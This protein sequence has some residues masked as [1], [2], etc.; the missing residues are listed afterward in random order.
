MR[1]IR[2]SGSVGRGLRPP[3]PIE[4]SEGPGG[5]DVQA[6]L[7]PGHQREALAGPLIEG[8]VGST[9]AGQPRWVG[10]LSLRRGRKAA[11]VSDVLSH[12]GQLVGPPSL[13]V[14]LCRAELYAVR[15]N[16]AGRFFLGGFC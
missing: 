8:T 3:Y 13:L 16:H 9:P 15:L 14:A 2:T 11:D 4:R 10:S 12:Q 6:Y 5:R 1:E 7:P